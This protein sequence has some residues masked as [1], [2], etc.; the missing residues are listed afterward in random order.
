[1]D[2]KPIRTEAEYDA[3]MVR[4]G[5][6][7]GTAAGT[8][9]ADE[10]EVLLALTGDYEGKHHPIAPPDHLSKLEYRLDQ[11]GLAPQEIERILSRTRDL[12]RVLSREL[13]IAP[14]VLSVLG[15]VPLE[16]FTRG[17]AG[18]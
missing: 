5:E 9:E 14:E 6:L 1:M 15:D 11:M 4:L 18:E 10:L 17:G 13:G 8:P 3:A 7:W 16:S 12:P 2:I